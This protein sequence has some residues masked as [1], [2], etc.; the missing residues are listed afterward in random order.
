VLSVVLLICE[1]LAN[2][3]EY[4]FTPLNCN[5]VIILKLFP[6]EVG[7]NEEDR[8]FVAEDRIGDGIFLNTVMNLGVS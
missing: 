7:F 4:C 1:L 8:T 3:Y 2:V 6:E 5:D